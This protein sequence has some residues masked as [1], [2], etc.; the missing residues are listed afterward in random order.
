MQ[1][2]DGCCSSLYTYGVRTIQIFARSIYNELCSS[3]QQ[4]I[5]LS[6]NIYKRQIFYSYMYQSMELCLQV[7]SWFSIHS[8]FSFRDIYFTKTNNQTFAIIL[9]YEHI[10][11]CWILIFILDV[12]LDVYVNIWQNNKLSIIAQVYQLLLFIILIVTYQ[13]FSNN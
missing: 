10:G 3:K 7:K 11:K 5:N 12:P 4:S 8:I 9:L 6:R 2:S 1:Q 13:K